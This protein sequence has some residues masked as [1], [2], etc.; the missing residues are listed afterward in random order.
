MNFSLS[1]ALQFPQTNE[2]KKEPD[3]QNKNINIKMTIKS[4]IYRQQ[5]NITE[6]MITEEELER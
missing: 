4:I 2:K 3:I 5:S 1:K 6:N